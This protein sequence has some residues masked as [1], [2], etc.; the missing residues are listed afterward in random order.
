VLTMRKKIP[1]A[2]ISN[3]SLIV[4]PALIS[5]LNFWK[6]N[7]RKNDI[8]VPKL[9]EL[10]KEHGQRSPIVVWKKNMVVYKGNTTLKAA[11][12]LGWKYIS[13]VLADFPSEE[14]AVAYGIADNKSS[15]WSQWDDGLLGKFL[16]TKEIAK[17]S[18]FTEVET[19]FMNLTVDKK[20]IDAIKADKSE[21]KARMI[22][23]VCS[24][25]MKIKVREM[26]LQFLSVNGLSDKVEVK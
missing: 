19:N 8:A 15:E 4:E 10:L 1:E 18:G 12:L 14:A 20:K 22:I 23:I 24:A 25:T 11:K 17:V 13:A 26:L 2:S 21:I 3:G 7:P 9:A 6:N 5:T 16:S